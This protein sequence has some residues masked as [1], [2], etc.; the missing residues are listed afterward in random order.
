MT[1]KNFKNEWLKWLINSDH[2][3]QFK[4]NVEELKRD[5]IRTE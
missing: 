2:S 3:N 5:I 1:R 4:I